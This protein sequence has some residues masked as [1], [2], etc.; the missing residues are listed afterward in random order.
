MRL[1]ST[2]MWHMQGLWKCGNRL[3]LGWITTMRILNGTLDEN[4]NREGQAAIPQRR[5]EVAMW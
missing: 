3:E 2:S 4:D 5:K 1:C